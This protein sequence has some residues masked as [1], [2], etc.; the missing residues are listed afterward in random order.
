MCL[1]AS[2]LNEAQCATESLVVSPPMPLHY[3]ENKMCWYILYGVLEG[4]L[5][6]SKLP[7][8][9]ETSSYLS[10]II[11]VDKKVTSHCRFLGPRHKGGTIMFNVQK[12]IKWA[13]FLIASTTSTKLTYLSIELWINRDS[14]ASRHKR[15]ANAGKDQGC[16]F[17]VGAMLC[18]NRLGMLTCWQ[19]KHCQAHVMLHRPN[20]RCTISEQYA[21]SHL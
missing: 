15:S 18:Q 21:K 10:N 5:Y 14:I 7:K 1:W 20:R 3:T 4:T 11:V 2:D 16:T 6:V 17:D 8:H 19:T 12:I 13:K 9:C